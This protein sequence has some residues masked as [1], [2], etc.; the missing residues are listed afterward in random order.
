MST[1][2]HSL[3]YVSYGYSIVISSEHGCYKLID[4]RLLVFEFTVV[5]G[6]GARH[7]AHETHTWLHAGGFGCFLP[8]STCPVMCCARA[9]QLMRHAGGAGM[10]ANP[11]RIRWGPRGMGGGAGHVR[12][13]EDGGFRNSLD[14]R[15]HEC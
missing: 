3:N 5:S 13:T 8:P 10:S 15:C 7:Y 12:S 4:P 2:E 11:C 6:L 9:F 1:A 14:Q